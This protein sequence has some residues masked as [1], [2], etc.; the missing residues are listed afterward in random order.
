[1]SLESVV[2][3][4]LAEQLRQRP[5]AVRAQQQGRVAERVSTLAG[6]GSMRVL[7][8]LVAVAAIATAVL[9]GLR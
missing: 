3:E 5:T 1:M 8:G 9:I 2:G 7:E 4:R 6:A